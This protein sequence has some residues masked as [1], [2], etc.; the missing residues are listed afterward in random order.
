MSTEAQAASGRPA[1]PR[2]HRGGGGRARAD[3]R[4][5]Y[6][7]VAPVIILLLAITAYPLLY[8]LWNSFHS[9]NLSYRQ[10]VAAVRRDWTT[11]RRCFAP[12]S[13]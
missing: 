8:N 5:G 12:P 6:A 11:T 4:L 13:G 1:S 9:V 10:P 2:R 7:L 3:R